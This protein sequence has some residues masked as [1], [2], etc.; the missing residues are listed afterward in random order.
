MRI[1]VLFCYNVKQAEELRVWEKSAWNSFGLPICT[2]AIP[3][4]FGIQ[5]LYLPAPLP[6]MIAMPILYYFYKLDKIYPQV[7]AEL[8]ERERNGKL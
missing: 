6:F 7:M 8:E 4:R 1:G 2:A 5:N 3:G